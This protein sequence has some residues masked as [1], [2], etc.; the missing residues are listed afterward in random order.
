[1]DT[2]TY[3]NGFRDYF[4]SH[5]SLLDEQFEYDQLNV[6]EDGVIYKN[7]TAKKIIF[8]EGFQTANNPFFSWLPFKLTKG[9]IITIQLEQNSVAD[10]NKVINKGV[11]ILPIG[12]NTYKVG[13]TYEWKD[14]TENTTEKG[15]ADL[16]EKL[17]KVLQVPFTIIDHKA[18]IRPTVNDRRPLIGIHPK[19]NSVAVF[20]GLGTKGVMLAHYFANHF[21]DFLENKASLDKEVDIKRFKYPE[22]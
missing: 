7:Y 15:K 13:A 12:D 16:I 6:E 20:N 22:K 10:I 1:M 21:S 3:L 11:F 5:N 8:C 14:L 18:G 17:K 19:H 9:E 4:I 2:L